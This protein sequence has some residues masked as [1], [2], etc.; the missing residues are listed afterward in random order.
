MKTIKILFLFV[1]M[2]VS[3][4]VSAQTYDLNTNHSSITMEV[5][6]LGWT[7]DI[8][9][10]NN[11]VSDTYIVSYSVEFTLKCGGTR[12]YTENNIGI[13]AGKTDD[14]GGFTISIPDVKG[15]EKGISGAK[16]IKFSADK[17][18]TPPTQSSSSSYS[19]NSNS[20]NQG[21]SS[22]VNNDPKPGPNASVQ[23][24]AAWQRRQNT[25]NN[26]ST[27]TTSSQSHSN[28]NNNTATQNNNNQGV[29]QAD[30]NAL[31]ERNAQESNRILGLSSSNVNKST[32]QVVE[33]G[34]VGI[35][36]ALL[37]ARQANQELEERE[38]ERK[39]IRAE[40]ERI[41]KENRQRI[42]NN[43]SIIINKF[44]AKDIPLS[45]RE[46][47]SK[48]YY[49]IYAFE[50]NNLNQEYGATVYVSNVFEIGTF[51][52]GTRAY[53]STVK[54]EIINLTPFNEVLH[55]YYYSE[56]EAE[57]IR[58]SFIELLKNN[59]VSIINISYKGKPGTKTETTTTNLTQT[60]E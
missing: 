20:S 36:N 50:N 39:R 11:H 2:L 8:F 48:I 53:T 58:K 4:K 49:F 6:N 25:V 31:L 28:Y 47:A 27:N 10:T 15:C 42:I 22:N 60:N 7:A 38:A 59:G 56:V 43:R 14:A 54:N 18:E 46:K 51:N 32:E 21:K 29:T 34:V 23:E 45:S 19:S 55:G 12:I 57:T 44:N 33:D 9:I 16:L 13:R 52:D 41:E 17:K 35:A 1:G 5:K 37:E 26:T 24:I 3:V 30:L 40:N